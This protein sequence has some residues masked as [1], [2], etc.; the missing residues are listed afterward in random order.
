LLAIPHFVWILLWS[1][2]AFVAALA[3]GIVAL[4]RGRSAAPL[5]RFLAAY[6]RYYTHL[7]AFLFLVANP[8]PSFT[9]T[10][11]YPV[12]VSVGPPERQ[13][14]WITL[15][16]IFLAIP[17]FLIAGVLGIV[18][19]IVGFFGWFAALLT[20]RMP[21]GF[22]NLGATSIRYL[23]QTNAYFFVVTD[24]YPHASPGLRAPAEPQL[25]PGPPPEP[26][27]TV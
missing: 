3:N 8:F 15:F 17:A 24:S 23:A 4:L 6:V 16:R 18:L 19:F 13:N 9:G 11:G 2:A 21:E 12:D 14:R 5:H 22:R 26:E 25:G 27:V 1:I 20:G 10:V 7:N